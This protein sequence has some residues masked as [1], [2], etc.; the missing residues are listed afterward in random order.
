MALNEKKEK[1]PSSSSR[2]KIEQIIEDS[3]GKLRPVRPEDLYIDNHPGVRDTF[4][5]IY[6]RQKAKYLESK[7]ERISKDIIGKPDKKLK[8]L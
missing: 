6:E 2:Y 4:K 8:P 5:M 1:I 3:D 7:R